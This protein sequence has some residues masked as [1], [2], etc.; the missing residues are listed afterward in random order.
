MKSLLQTQ[1]WADFRVSQ[2]WKAHE[3]EG[4]FVLE[5]R[6]PFG[7]SFLYAPEVS[8]AQIQNTNF[9]T[10][11]QKNIKKSGTIFFRLEILDENDPEIIE[12]LK[13]QK[14]IK[15]FEELQPEYRQIIDITPSE[16]EILAQMKEKGRYNIKV[17]QRNGVVIKNSKNLPAGRQGID[18]FY[19][20][21]IETAKRDGFSIRPRE[22]FVKMTEILGEN[23]PAGRQGVEL[24][25][26]EFQGKIIAAEIVSFY[27]NTA[28]YLYGASGSEYRNV[29]A[30]YLLHWE[31]IKLAKE[32]GCQLYDLLAV[33]PEKEVEHKFAGI[34]RFKRQF[35]GR[36]V[37][38][39][40][41]YD[42]V[43]KPTWYS[44]FKF[45][46]RIRR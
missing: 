17:A 8:W 45:A 18:D 13:S 31:A 28:S 39:T 7:K 42:L 34:G 4:I 36:T 26:A 41:A 6:L 10:N 37:R 29:M 27:D 19:K 44:L 12:K 2:G 25:Y 5:R 30:P 32:K 43:Y 3:I 38:I 21:F 1:E 23:L 14:F 40:G 22:Y 15:A 35:G 46:E 16:D 24:L 20:I 11:I 33:N 9:I